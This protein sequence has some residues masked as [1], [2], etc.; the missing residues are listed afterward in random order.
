MDI[1]QSLK[2][3]LNRIEP[4]T[5][6]E[7]QGF[8]ALME[9]YSV[10]KNDYLLREG[11]TEKYIHFV[12]EGL[13]RVFLRDEAKEISLDFIFASQFVSS[14]S[15][16][17]QQTPSKVN[18]QAL[19]DTQTFRLSHEKLYAFYNVSHKAERVGRIIAEQAYIRKT[20]REI[21]F[22]KLTAKERYE[23][24]LEQNPGLV[25]HIPVKY[26]ASYLGIE[27]ESLSRIRR[28]VN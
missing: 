28:M 21:A 26:L 12:N 24:L 16:F 7:W 10:S 5:E 19:A 25:Q 9:P 20:N 4:H 27:P 13:V 3:Q 1:Y 22:L 18:I 17:L 14:Y 6:E 11:Q 23:Q 15:S 8:L 2:N